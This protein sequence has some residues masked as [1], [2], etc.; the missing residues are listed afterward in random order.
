[1]TPIDVK[2]PMCNK[3]LT[4]MEAELLLQEEE[5]PQQMNLFTRSEAGDDSMHPAFRRGGDVG[6]KGEGD[7]G[8]HRSSGDHVAGTTR[9]GLR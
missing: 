7:R 8:D 9:G 6:D 2:C 3:A 4:R 5:D 1:M